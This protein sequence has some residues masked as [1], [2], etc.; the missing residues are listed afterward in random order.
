MV[1]IPVT[2]LP[3]SLVELYHSYAYEA[4]DHK[5]AFAYDTYDEWLSG[6]NRVCIHADIIIKALSGVDPRLAAQEREFFEKMRV[7][8]RGRGL[9]TMVVLDGTELSCHN[10]QQA[11]ELAPWF[12][13]QSGELQ[14]YLQQHISSIASVLAGGQVRTTRG[15]GSPFWI[16]GT[17]TI[18][19]IA[20]RA[21]AR[22]AYDSIDALEEACLHL[23]PDRPTFIQTSYIRI[24]SAR[25]RTAAFR[26]RADGALELMGDRVGP[27]VRRIAAQPF[28]LNH[29]IAPYG[30]I[31]R[32]FMAERHGGLNAG[33]INPVISA[34]RRFKWLVAS[35]LKSYDT[36][37]SY[38][39]LRDFQ[40]IVVNPMIDWVWRHFPNEC[41]DL[42]LASP[43]LIDAIDIKMQ[44]M[45]VLTAPS[46]PGM[47][48]YLWPASGQTRSGENLTS[49]KGTMIRAAH[50]L[51]KLLA[52]GGDPRRDIV[53]N[54]GDDTLLMTNDSSLVDRWFAASD[55][56]GLVEVAAA[57]STFLMRR[58][59]HG[60]S[61]LGRMV[62][63]CVNREPKQEPVDVIAAASSFGTRYALLNGS[64]LQQHYFPLLHSY[65]GPARMKQAVQLA[66]DQVMTS[67]PSDV[68]ARAVLLNQVA[69]HQAEIRGGQPNS[70]VEDSLHQLQQ[71]R[72]QVDMTE[73][74]LQLIAEATST[75][76]S[77]RRYTRQ[78]LK[79]HELDSASSSFGV[80]NAI[81]YLRGVLRSQRKGLNFLKTA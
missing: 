69:S 71:L 66:Q 36:T 50:A 64:P 11:S 56:L 49:F 38:E 31:L 4:T 6:V 80:T 27:K 52:C 12:R 17:D 10:R 81:E 54:Y 63:A 59:P 51:D 65:G 33:Q 7:N 1:G 34:A 26:M 21:L 61:Y 45:P 78:F 62:T 46:G 58:I 28:L 47:A 60:Y 14:S 43:G 40:S 24:Q 68:I 41:R 18:G 42:K 73:T 76:Q 35:D 32:S 22:N 9:G 55:H 3:P 15:K 2:A 30:D 79:W 77:G 29:W 19:A 44:N 16:P 48:A 70:N 53:F 74:S 25:N 13:Q 5:V 72:Q 8:W 20:L 67:E 37:V 39:T 23:A 75:I 57:D